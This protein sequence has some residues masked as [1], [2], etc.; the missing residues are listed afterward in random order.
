MEGLRH[1]I[2]LIRSTS[3]SLTQGKGVKELL[4]GI[5]LGEWVYSGILIAL[6]VLVWIS[7]YL[8]F[9][10]IYSGIQ[11]WVLGVLAILA[12]SVGVGL[13]FFLLHPVHLAIVTYFVISILAVVIFVLAGVDSFKTLIF[14]YII[15]FAAICFGYARVK[16]EQRILIPFLYSRLIRR[17]MPVFFTGLAFTLALLYNSSPIGS[18][19]GVPQFSREFVR[20][21]FVPVEY[22]IKPLVPDFSP[23]M[24]IKDIGTLVAAEVLPSSG[25]STKGLRSGVG[26]APRSTGDGDELPNIFGIPLPNISP[27]ISSKIF[28]RIGPAISANLFS[29]LPEEDQEKTLIQYIHETVNEQ[30]NAILLPYKQ[31][32]SVIYLFGLFLVFKAIAMPLMWVSMGAGWII[33][34]IL[35]QYG[36]FKIKKIEV[37]K[38]ELA[39]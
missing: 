31:I 19:L 23:S 8:G 9:Y 30:L 36:V 34:R 14:A 16:L 28:S 20:V 12:L 29:D 33:S 27:E 6:G 37:E 21:M 35:M 5:S 11:V 10:E 22:I 24:K 7:V 4:G 17:G 26:I 32:L 2:G 1:K 18:G 38:E 25:E 3:P 13:S 15:F 39:L